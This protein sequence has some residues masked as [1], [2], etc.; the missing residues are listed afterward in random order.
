VKVKKKANG[1]G[2][3]KEVAGGGER[4]S[5]GKVGGEAG[6]GEGKE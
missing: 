3:K 6:E 1:K 2:K 5:D 4:E